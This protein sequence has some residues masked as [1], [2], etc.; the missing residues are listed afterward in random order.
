MDKSDRAKITGIEIALIAFMTLVWFF[1]AYNIPYMHDDWD[2]GLKYGMDHL[3]NADLNSRYAGNLLEV[4][5]TRS[6]VLKTLFLGL[7]YSLIPLLMAGLKWEDKGARLRIY[8]ISNLLL[9]LMDVNIW[10]ETYGW[11]AGAAN[12][13]LVMPLVLI[14]LYV[15]RGKNF[16]RI[17]QRA[18]LFILAIVMQLF[19][20]NV[21]LATTLISLCCLID[22]IRRKA[23]DKITMALVFGGNLTGTL[24]CLFSGTVRELVGTGEAVDGYRRFIFDMDDPLPVKITKSLSFL[25]G[26]CI[27]PI[28]DSWNALVTILIVLVLTVLVWQ[29]RKKSISRAVLYCTSGVNS[30]IVVYLALSLFIDLKSLAGFVGI[31]IFISVLCELMML[32]HQDVRLAVILWIFAPLVISPMCILYNWGPRLYV[33]T[34]IIHVTTLALLSG[35]LK[36]RASIGRVRIVHT[37]L[38]LLLV[39]R[40]ALMGLIYFD[41]GAATSRRLDEIRRARQGE[42]TEVLLE[43]YPHEIYLHDP[44]PADKGREVFF[45]E[46]YKIPDDVTIRMG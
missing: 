20:E 7:G 16:D 38:L 19:L 4:L 8:L 18:L 24:I 34:Y 32:D 35:M 11:V 36:I 12:Y 26:S 3:I 1:I 27:G 31:A 29:H 39:I 33:T 45:R 28:Y 46:F 9:L 23:G 6:A 10:C 2:W 41:I 42:I 40:A 15:V 43:R 25:T 13:I 22:V 14:W 37:G 17:W 5:M 21:A 44:D 30:A